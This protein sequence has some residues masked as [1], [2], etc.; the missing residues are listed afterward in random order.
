M[1]R[2]LVSGSSSKFLAGILGLGLGSRVGVTWSSLDLSREELA[3]VFVEEEED[4]R[5]T[6][7]EVE[8]GGKDSDR[9]AELTSCICE[10]SQLYGGHS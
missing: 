1:R 8:C 3:G 6:F 10:I 9:G 2:G 5:E 7:A 4:L